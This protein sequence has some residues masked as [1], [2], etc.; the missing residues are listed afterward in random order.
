MFLKQGGSLRYCVTGTGLSM[1]DRMNPSTLFLC[2]W[3][4]AGQECCLLISA[5]MIYFLMCW[6]CCCMNCSLRKV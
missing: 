1:A 2:A 4:S 5:L 3:A 6:Q